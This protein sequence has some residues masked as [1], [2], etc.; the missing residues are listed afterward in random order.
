MR[1]AT[2]GRVSRRG[3]GAL[4]VSGLVGS[5]DADFIFAA[6]A[7]VAGGVVADVG[8]MGFGCV[9]M[10]TVVDG[11]AVGLTQGGDVGEFVLI[12]DLIVAVVGMDVAPLRRFNRPI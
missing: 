5:R 4:D 8:E 10:R 1:P 9:V 6:T 7:M 11:A 12:G 2:R 3:R